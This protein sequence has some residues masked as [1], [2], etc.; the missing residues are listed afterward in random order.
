MTSERVIIEEQYCGPPQS[1][2]GGYTAGL[3]A[4]RIDG[5][6]SV[7]LRA[8]P[9]LDRPLRVSRSETGIVS[10]H[11]ADTLLAEAHARSVELALPEAV[12]FEQAERATLN[13]PGPHPHPYPRCFVCGPERRRGDGLAVYPGEVEGRRVVASPWLPSRELCSDGGVVD[14]HFVWAALDCPSWFGF[15]TFEGEV[16]PSL[17]GRLAV[18]IRR[19]PHCDERCVIVGWHV[20]REGRR[21]ECGSMLL[22]A[23]HGECLAYA[24]STWVTL[25]PPA[26]R[27]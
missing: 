17:L 13:Y 16:P 25:K 27:T 20:G 18:D 14:A 21:I 10:L 9:P 7:T 22:D 19:R 8:P 26:L 3:L 24:L 6:C 5:P 12:S 11:D 4:E 23:E 15:S 1:A 2:N